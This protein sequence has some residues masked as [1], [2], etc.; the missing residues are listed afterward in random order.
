MGKGPW[1]QDETEPDAWKGGLTCFLRANLLQPVIL[2]F[3]QAQDLVESA[4]LIE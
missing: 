3:S 2:Q 1:Q 4:P